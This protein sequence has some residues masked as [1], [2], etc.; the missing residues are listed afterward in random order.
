MRLRNKVGL[1]LPPINRRCVAPPGS[2][3]VGEGRPIVVA[4]LMRSG[5]HLLIDLI[6]N[7]F[8]SYRR[9]PLYLNL[10]AYLIERRASQGLMNCGAYV[11]KTHFP[12]IPVPDDT[13]DDL[14]R[15]AERAVVLRP[16]RGLA[17]THRSLLS[18]GETRSME[19]LVACKA[20]ADAFWDAFDPLDF[21][22]DDLATPS[23]TADIVT[24]I[25][26][27]TGLPLPGRVVVTPDKS[28][29]IRI[30]TAK[31]LTRLLGHRA[32]RLNTTI[33]FDSTPPPPPP[34]PV[35]AQS[36]SHR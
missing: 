7:N 32:P 12:Q 33:Q 11:A 2:L 22:F 27:R 29:A 24:R 18:F 5:T 9:D 3:P 4:S 35:P 23:L 8:A 25:A 1:I 34:L 19:E 10:D 16:V 6:L 36:E 15:F 20:A 30:L 13:L 28:Q 17:E 14:R 21:S 31:L 26:E